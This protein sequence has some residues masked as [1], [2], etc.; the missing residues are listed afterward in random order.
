VIGRGVVAGLLGT[1]AMTAVQELLA[2]ESGRGEPDWDAAP[3][4]AQVARKAL[5]LA[6][7]DPPASWI[8]ALTNVMH[9][10]YGTTWGVVH[11]LVR[12]KR[13]EHLIRE[14][15]AFGT[16]VWAASYA[17]LVPLGIYEPP[18]AYDAKT[19]AEDLTY[20]LAFGVGTAATA[21]AL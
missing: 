15:V 2:G 5:R 12:G 16:L 9:W 11:S 21:A 4:P 13:D 1:A 14:G 10:G 7:F 3:A 6:G 17:E 20:P 19:L 18:W 8:P